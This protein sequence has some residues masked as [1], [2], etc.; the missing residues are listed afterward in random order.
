M[1]LG[2]I[3]LFTT[4]VEALATALGAGILLGGFVVGSIGIVA[5]WPR[6][7]LDER[8][9]AFGYLGGIV[10]AALAFIDLILR[11]RG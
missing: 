11:Y 1:A 9:L 10:G 8:V 6:P 5:G 3:G 2:Q 4:V 7:L